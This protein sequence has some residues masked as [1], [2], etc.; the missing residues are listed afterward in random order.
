MMNSIW[1]IIILK[2]QFDEYGQF[3]GTVTVYGQDPIKHVVSWG[4]SGGL[5]NVM[6][7]ILI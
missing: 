2:V 7:S 4:K 1:L 5:R 3:D 6:R